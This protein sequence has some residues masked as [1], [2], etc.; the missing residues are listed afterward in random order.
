MAGKPPRRCGDVEGERMT[1]NGD[2][3]Y[4]HLRTRVYREGGWWVAQLG[5]WPWLLVS[6]TLAGMA[7]LINKEHGKEGRQNEK[8][9]Q[10][11]ALCAV[12]GRK[13]GL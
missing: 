9:R 8:V 12:S 6:D 7:R 4:T 1:K 3:S 2:G 11:T 13:R 5:F 10:K